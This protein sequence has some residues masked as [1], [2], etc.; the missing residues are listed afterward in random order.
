[1]NLFSWKPG[2]YFSLILITIFLLWHF[3]QN[4]EKYL[5]RKTKELVQLA[6]FSSPLSE[7]KAISRINKITAFLNFDVFLKAEDQ[8]RKFTAKNLQEVKS[9]LFPYFLQSQIAKWDAEDLTVKLDKPTKDSKTA[10][11][12]LTVKGHLNSKPLQCKAHLKWENKKKW[13]ISR[14]QVFSCLS[15]A[16]L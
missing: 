1:M 9:F 3:P 5:K 2:K 16:P 6:S 7:L 4:N 10:S 12:F 15:P 14:I 8:G 11:V 13:L